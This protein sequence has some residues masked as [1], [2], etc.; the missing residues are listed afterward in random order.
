MISTIIIAISGITI[1]ILWLTGVL[2]KNTSSSSVN[3]P[4]S[5]QI[6]PRFEGYTDPD[7][8]TTI[9]IDG[10]DLAKLKKADNLQDLT[11]EKFKDDITK[12][13]EA[14][15]VGNFR[16]IFNA[17]NSYKLFLEGIISKKIKYHTLDFSIHVIT[18]TVYEYF[19]TLA[20]LGLG[21]TPGVFRQYNVVADCGNSKVCN[22]NTFQKVEVTLQESPGGSD[23]IRTY[24]FHKNQLQQ[25]D[26]EIQSSYTSMLEMISG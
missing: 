24:T 6:D 1:L 22:N 17:D 5:Y 13:M 25:Y 16:Q 18:Y 14:T 9:Q 3:N 10:N 19:V 11:N 26:E 23:D 12:L 2:F 20:N 8:W 21:N 7:W 4:D 15:T